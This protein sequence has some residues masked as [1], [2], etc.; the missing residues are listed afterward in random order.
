MAGQEG[1]KGGLRRLIPPI[2]ESLEQLAVGPAD[3][4]AGVEEPAELP[5]EVPHR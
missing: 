2:R 3:G 5:T 4:A 1:F